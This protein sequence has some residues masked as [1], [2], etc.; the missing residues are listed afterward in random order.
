MACY[1]FAG[2]AH[3][4]TTQIP[5]DA[6]PLTGSLEVLPRE[7]AP[8]EGAAATPLLD[9][10]C[11][12]KLRLQAI[13]RVG[14]PCDQGGA[15]LTCGCLNDNI[16]DRSSGTTANVESKVTDLHDG[17][18]LLEWWSVHSGTYE[19]YVKLAGLHVVNSPA[20][21]Q[22][23]SGKPDYSQTTVAVQMLTGLVAGRETK[24]IMRRKGFDPGGLGPALLTG[25]II[26]VLAP[27]LH[28]LRSVLKRSVT[29]VL[30]SLRTKGAAHVPR[31]TRQSRTAGAEVKV[32]CHLSTDH[33]Q[34]H[35]QPRGG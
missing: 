8:L 19:V 24:Y 16:K 18:Y 26:V 22:L 30:D 12:C 32:L 4:L 11:V 9:P 23:T 20:C 35:V 7:E 31:C 1:C 27:P 6:L 33:F 15:D 3:A 34:S 13:D 5:L 21:M 28:T 10:R 25:G 17:T 14:N 2:A 29:S